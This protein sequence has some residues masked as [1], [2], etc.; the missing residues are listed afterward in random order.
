[1]KCILGTRPWKIKL[2][3]HSQNGHGLVNEKTQV[4]ANHLLRFLVELQKQCYS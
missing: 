4:T 1:M 2:G 3:A